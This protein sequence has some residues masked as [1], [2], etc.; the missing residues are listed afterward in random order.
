MLEISQSFTFSTHE[1]GT[2]TVQNISSSVLVMQ[3]RDYWIM[4][5]F[6]GDSDTQLDQLRATKIFFDAASAGPTEAR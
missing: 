3:A 2:S 1:P 5:M 4:W 6:M